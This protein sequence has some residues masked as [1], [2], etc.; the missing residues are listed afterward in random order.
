MND[1]KGSRAIGSGQKDSKR[2]PEPSQLT[3]ET[4]HAMYELA[5][6]YKTLADLLGT[7]PNRCH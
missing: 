6:N 5:E 1:W 3:R 2:P 7:L 4:K